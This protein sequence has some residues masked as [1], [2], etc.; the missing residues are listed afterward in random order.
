MSIGIED[1]M[2]IEI[3][4]SI[5]SLLETE[6]DSNYSEQFTQVKEV[7][8]IGLVFVEATNKKSLV[9]FLDDWPS[10]ELAIKTGHDLLYSA[11]ERK[12]L[13]AF[14]EITSSQFNFE[15]LIDSLREE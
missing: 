3:R 2:L 1:Y 9:C 5:V 12:Y 14:D 7:A 13:K 8:L 15:T 6:I 4:R 10:I 11:K